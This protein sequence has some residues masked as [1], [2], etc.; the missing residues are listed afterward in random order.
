MFKGGAEEKDYYLRIYNHLSPLQ[1]TILTQHAADIKSYTEERHSLVS[2]I[3]AT[4]TYRLVSSSISMMF[5]IFLMICSNPLTFLTRPFNTIYVMIYFVVVYSCLFVLNILFL[6]ARLWGM[7]RLLSYL[8]DR[9]GGGWSITNWFDINLFD[10][11]RYIFDNASS[12]LGSNLNEQVIEIEDNPNIFQTLSSKPLEFNVD[13]ARSILL[14]CS[15]VYERDTKVVQEAAQTNLSNTVPDESV[16]FLIKSEEHM[17]Q[18]ADEWGIGFVSVADFRK[19]S[20]PFAGCFYSY[21]NI[22]EDHNP[23]IVL[24]IKGTSPTDF[25]EWILDAECKLESVGDFLATGM[26]HEGFYTSIFPPK[27]HCPRVLPYFRMIQLVRM[28]AHTAFCETGK[29]SNLFIGGHSMGAGIASLIYARL[30]QSPEDLGEQIILRDAYVFGTPRTC[31]GK[32]ASRVDFNLTKPINEGRQIWRVCN[33]SRSPIIGD[34]VTRVP[35]G[36]ATSREIRGA[37][38]DG[39]YFS[40]ANIGIRLDM[41]PFQEPPFYSIKDIPSGYLVSVCKRQQDVED[42][43]VRY[44][45]ISQGRFPQDI[46]QFTMEL[47]GL[48]LPFIHDHFPAS[49]MNALNK[50]QAKID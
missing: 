34:I 19:L 48:F 24:A 22:G 9:Y 23:Y 4:Q 39:S 40:Y 43:F 45:G 17:L 2:R 12:A 13:I 14:M 5:R 26:A 36:I 47:L 27:S 44:Q 31:D 33:R 41:K 30:L 8:G 3:E 10:S 37:L 15:I 42:D 49:Y 6:C 29:R 11:K 46:V 7:G 16:L 21:Q 25:T 20:G 35:P 1:R 28:I 32:L 18:L 50:M 38:R